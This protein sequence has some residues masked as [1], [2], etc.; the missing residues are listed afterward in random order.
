MDFISNTRTV[1]AASA[2]GGSSP[3]AMK[4]RGTIRLFADL[5]HFDDLK[6][7]LPELADVRER[8][9]LYWMFESL[10]RH[11]GNNEVAQFMMDQVAR[12]ANKMLKVSLLERIGG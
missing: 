7:L 1:L 5:N 8:D 10:V 9:A 2:H 4:A 11:T 6:L 3:E 12:E